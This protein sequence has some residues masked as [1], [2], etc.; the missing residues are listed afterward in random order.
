MPVFR[1]DFRRRNAAD[2]A[3]GIATSAPP[4]LMASMAGGLTHIVDDDEHVRL[5]TG[6]ILEEAGYEARLYASGADFFARADLSVPACL[7]LDLRMPEMSGEAILK[8][9]A[10][11][12]HPLSVVVV[13]GHV[14]V[15][16]AVA[17]MHGG[18]A[19]VIE[20]PWKPADLLAAVAEAFAT[21]APPPPADEA[22][23]LFARLTPRER[24]VVEAVAVHGANR[25]IAD[26][27]GLS[28][29]TV[30]WYRAGAMKRLG[31]SSSAEMLNL[32]FKAKDGSAATVPATP[33]TRRSRG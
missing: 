8:R 7:V 20:K 11:R 10:K 32:Y 27:L 17:A 12:E 25:R 2:A 9:L 16:R 26:A 24:D 14:D 21:H 29:R 18:A 3:A 6:D 31:V 13:S 23:D 19:S 4:R 1:C 33:P 22:A 15:P 5:I 30:E 28:V